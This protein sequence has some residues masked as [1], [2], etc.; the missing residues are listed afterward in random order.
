MLLS[1]VSHFHILVSIKKPTKCTLKDVSPLFQDV[2]EVGQGMVHRILQRIHECYGW[3]LGMDPSSKMRTIK[4][5][6]I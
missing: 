3:E 6:I 5:Y 2:Q 4:E 1:F